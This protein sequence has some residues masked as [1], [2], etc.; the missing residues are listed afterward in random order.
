[1]NMA[2]P[3]SIRLVLPVSAS[4]VIEVNLD[5]N[6]A[7]RKIAGHG[8]ISDAPGR[9]NFGSCRDPDGIDLRSPFS[10]CQAVFRMSVDPFELLPADEFQRHT[11]LAFGCRHRQPVAVRGPPVPNPGAV[12][13]SFDPEIGAVRRVIHPEWFDIRIDH[14]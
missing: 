9:G 8:Q 14:S 10:Q 1:M 7:L 4:S 12:L 13:L 6:L 5:S 2:D 11:D 3:P